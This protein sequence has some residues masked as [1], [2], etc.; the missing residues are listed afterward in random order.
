MGTP[1]LATNTG[2]NVCIGNNPQATGAFS[3]PDF[4]FADFQD[5]AD[6][7]V[8]VRRDRTLTRRGASWAVHH[9]G[10]EPRLVFW[11]TYWTFESDHDGLRAVQ[12]YEED[13][14]IPPRT[15]AVLTTVADG[16]YDAVVAL[17]ALGTLLLWRRRDA[18]TGLVVL[19]AAALAITVWPFFGDSRFHLP[20]SLLLAVPAGVAL[21]AFLF[22]LPR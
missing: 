6:H 4:C 5:L 19:A 14:W 15:A 16:Y 17:A 22:R 3:L 11:R 21:E 8:E 7:T 12:S 10:A 9:L 18:R 13:Q 1:T 20:V 2:D